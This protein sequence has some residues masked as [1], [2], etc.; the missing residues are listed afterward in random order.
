MNQLQMEFL[1]PVQ[2]SY[3]NNGFILADGTSIPFQF[4][5]D[6]KKQLLNSFQIYDF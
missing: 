4:S 5:I 1:T 3:N 6:F 2:K